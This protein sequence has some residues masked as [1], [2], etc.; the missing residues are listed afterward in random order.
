MSVTF[1]Q[2]KAEPV[3]TKV[4]DGATAVPLRAAVIG[5][6]WIAEQVYLPCLLDH[7]GI[8]VVAAHDES[9]EVLLRFAQSAGLS[10][11]ALSLDQCFDSG[12]QGVILCTP[13]A[14]HAQQIA[15]LVARDKAVLCEKPVF[16]EVEELEK[17]GPAS[18]VARRLMGSAS[19]RLREDVSLLLHWVKEGVLGPLESVHL[20]WWRERGVPCAGSWR[21]DPSQCPLGVMEDLGP[22]LLDLLAALI[23]D[24]VW[25]E[26]RVVSALLECR[27][28]NDLRR[29]ASWFKS[30]TESPYSVPDYGS[31]EFLSDTGT[32]IAV[33]VCWANPLPGDYCTLKFKGARG[34]AELRGL[35]G[36]STLRRSP[37]QVCVLERA[38][39][40]PETHEFPAGREM[41]TRA[42]AESVA[43][44]SRF[45]RSL[46]RPAADFTEI[47]RVTEWLSAIREAAQ[48]NEITSVADSKEQIR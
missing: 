44:F 14:V 45:C 15:R 32:R 13:P 1:E 3:V 10:S 25:S 4:P 28:G 37:E 9:P 24:G 36:L 35:L 7:G 29:S 31:A 27:H 40:A 48:E 33:E 46:S 26:L 43:I 18:D 47:R 20:G 34:T 16:R 17:I 5:T 19:M 12:V 23:S 21:T 6:G 11:D 30:E 42:F 41:Q 38:G 2:P 39:H 22:H 8:E